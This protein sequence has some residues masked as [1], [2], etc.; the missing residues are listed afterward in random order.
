MTKATDKIRMLTPNDAS[1]ATVC[2]TIAALKEWVNEAHGATPPAT[3]A[4]DE[5][6][7][8]FTAFTEHVQTLVGDLQG[9]LNTALERIA[10]LESKLAQVQLPPPV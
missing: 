5:Y 2:A 6:E 1:P 4:S 9:T 8:A 10:T 7:A 3:V